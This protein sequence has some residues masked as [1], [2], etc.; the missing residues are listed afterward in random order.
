M[1]SQSNAGQTTEPH[2]IMRFDDSGRNGKAFV[3]DLLNKVLSPTL[4]QA[5]RMTSEDAP[6]GA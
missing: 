2:F 1:S 6:I 5:A 3:S 4:T